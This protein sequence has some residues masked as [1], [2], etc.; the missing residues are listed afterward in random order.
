MVPAERQTENDERDEG[1]IKGGRN[2]C[3]CHQTYVFQR[4]TFVQDCRAAKNLLPVHRIYA[5]KKKKKKEMC[6]V[7]A[8][9]VCAVFIWLKF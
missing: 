7:I 6:S 2:P 4:E 8:S 1:L 5:Q 3:C 9:H